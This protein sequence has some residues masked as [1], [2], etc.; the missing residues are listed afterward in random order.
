MGKWLFGLMILLAGLTAGAQNMDE[1]V[2]FIKQHP[3]K[4]SIYLIENGQATIDLN[5]GQVMPLASAAK[6][7]IAISF[8]K[9]V[10]AKKISPDTKVAVQDLAKYYIPNTDGQAH[11]NW[12]KSIGKSATDSVTLLQVAKGMIRFSSNANTEYL[13]DLLGLAN[14]NNTMASLPLK[15]HQPLYYF[16]AGATMATLRP[17]GKSNEEWIK[18]LRDLSSAA[19]HQKC[20]EAHRKLKTD[21]NYVKQFSFERLPLSVQKVWSDRLVGSTTYDYAQLMQKILGGRFFE[22]GVQSVLESIMEWPMDYPGNKAVFNHLGQKGGSTAFVLT[23]AFYAE[24]KNG[25]QIACAFFFN[26]LDANESAMVNKYFGNFEASILT[27]SDFRK[28]LA[29]ALR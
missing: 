3:Q 17:T 15:S 2:L 19:Y 1:L 28:K 27:D 26:D 13:Q 11:P 29:V 22:P 24:A 21:P 23:D 5:S 14:I 18:E 4:A 12:L 7:M 16:T 9:Q 8:A 20:E 25:T 6:T 10:A